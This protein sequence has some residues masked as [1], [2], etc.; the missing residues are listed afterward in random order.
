MIEQSILKA[1]SA[2]MSS[3]QETIREDKPD[4]IAEK[5]DA[6]FIDNCP[7]GIWRIGLREPLDLSLS[8]SAQISSTLR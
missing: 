8:I 1:K 7:F 2:R 6:S 4:L 3:S 5:P